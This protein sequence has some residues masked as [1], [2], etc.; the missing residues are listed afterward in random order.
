M[1]V[2]GSA[3]IEAEFH[4]IF[5]RVNKHTK[6]K[7]V[8][9]PK[10]VRKKMDRTI[11]AYDIALKSGYI[12]SEKSKRKFVNAKKNLKTLKKSEFAEIAVARSRRHP[13]GIEALTFEY[14]YEKAR[15]I[16][17]KRNSRLRRK[18]RRL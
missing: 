12:E 15:E 9:S 2:E 10:D 3:S 5:K 1:W 7:G 6:M 18:R 4:G 16:L 11:K 13:H 17:L 14:G 8:Q